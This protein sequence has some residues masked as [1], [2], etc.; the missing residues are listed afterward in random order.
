MQ[1]RS[2]SPMAGH[3][4]RL[5]LLILRLEVGAPAI[6]III[7][8]GIQTILQHIPVASSVSFHGPT[9][10]CWR[11]SPILARARCRTGLDAA[12]SM[13]LVKHIPGTR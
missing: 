4:V 8:A 6:I 10:I 2:P 5:N 11:P 13:A 1:P 3:T 7:L 12:N 9:L